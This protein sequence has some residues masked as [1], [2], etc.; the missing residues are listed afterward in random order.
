MGSALMTTRARKT[1]GR[2]AFVGSG[3]GDGG[4]LTVRGR[5]LLTRAELVV[6]DPDVP[7]DVV[8]LVG[9]G[10][11]V[12]PAVGDP[13]DVARDLATEAKA[14]RDVVRLVAGAGELSGPLVVTVGSAVAGRQRLSWWESRALYG[15]KVLVPRTKEQ[16]GAMS[17]RLRAHG[18]IPVEV[19]TISVEPPRSPAQMERSVK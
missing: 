17:E 8:A 19:P 13:D 6:T 12:R 7:S 4:L 2:V 9:E 10:V 14:G 11:E 1:P 15:W 18:A 5:E 16:A 3:P